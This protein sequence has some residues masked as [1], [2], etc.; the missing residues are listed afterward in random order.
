MVTCVVGVAYQNIRMKSEFSPTPPRRSRF[1]SER[2]AFHAEL[3]LNELKQIR[4]MGCLIVDALKNCIGNSVKIP[5][6]S[7]VVIRTDW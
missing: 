1:E 4:L 3:I 7:L 2:K 6:L 5:C